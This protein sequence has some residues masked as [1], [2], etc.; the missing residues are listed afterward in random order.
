[1]IPLTDEEKEFY[2]R[3]EVCHMCKEEF[4]TDENEKNKVR[5]HCHYTR[6]FRGAAHGIC[7]LRQKVPKKIPIVANNAAHDHHFIIKQLGEEVGGQFK[8]IGEND[9]K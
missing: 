8:C 1:M 3:Q 9:K 6:K 5:D 4:C 2:E 7:N